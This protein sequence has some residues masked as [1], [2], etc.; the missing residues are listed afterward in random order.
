[1]R[2][3]ALLFIGSTLAVPFRLLSTA[4]DAEPARPAD[5]FVDFVGVNTHVGYSDTTYA[6]YD[7]I[8]KPRL[9]ELDV[10]HIRDSTFNSE[11]LRSYL[12]LRQ[13][14]DP[15]P[16]YHGLKTDR[17]KGAQPRTDALRH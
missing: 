15:A 9:L 2:R 10:R 17:R 3:F 13:T 11:G 1:M 16:S 6:D 14:R 7:G 8:L 12:D 5:A 4:A